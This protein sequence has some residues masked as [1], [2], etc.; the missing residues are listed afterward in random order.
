DTVDALNWLA[1]SVTEAGIQIPATLL[2][3][4]SSAFGQE[5]GSIYMDN[6]LKIAEEKGMTP[7]QVI[8]QG[9]DDPA[10][11]IAFGSAASALD[12]IGAKGVVNVSKTTLKK[13]LASRTKALL[14]SSGGESLTEGA[15]TG[16]EQVG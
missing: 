4:G 5:V 6:V 11:A 16:L 1:G 12:F 3:F 15:Q 9:L 13:A 10:S 2:S 8:D 14:K 7:E